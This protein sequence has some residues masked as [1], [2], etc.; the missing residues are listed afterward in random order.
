MSRYIWLFLALAVLLPFSPASLAA[1]NAIDVIASDVEVDFPRQAVFTVDAQSQA[2]IVDVRLCYRVEKMNYAQVVSE[3]WA[4]FLPARR[5]R[6]T[7]VWDM[8]HAGLPPGAEVLYWW[9]IEDAQGNRFQTPS[10]IMHFDDDRYQWRSRSSVLSGTEEEA[11]PAIEVTIFWYQGDDSFAEKLMDVCLEGLA[12]LAQE[13]GAYTEKP[14][15]IY[16][17]ASTADLQG[18]MVFSQEWTGGVAFAQFGI[19][20]IAIPPTRLDWGERAL[21]HE[22]TH[23]VVHQ[24]TFGPYG[25]LPTWLDE[26][27]AMYNEGELDPFLNSY[28]QRA[29]VQ[30]SLISVRTLC[31]PFSADPEKAYLSY[32]ESYGLVEYLLTGYGRNRMLDLLGL[33]REGSGYDEALSEV[34]GFDING[35]DARWRAALLSEASIDATSLP[36]GEGWQGG[37]QLHPALM[38]VL[39]ALA[40]V[41]LLWAA[42][43]LEEWDWQKRNRRS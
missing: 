26:G 27:L 21:V 12:R 1:D 17:Y 11:L 33:L 34:Y 4:N 9:V 2:D 39:A 6:A 7:W 10:Q 15:R 20:A 24:A 23:L 8:R 16:V 25:Q 43:S 38:A 13:I 28:L 5:V 14:I 3:G 18:A 19:I 32:A 29:I 35:L 41:L 36:A 42:L 30:D 22:L 31:S 40:T 37:W